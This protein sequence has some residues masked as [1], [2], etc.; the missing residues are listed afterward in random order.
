M[1]ESNIHSFVVSDY[2]AVFN[3]NGTNFTS[4]KVNENGMFNITVNDEDLLSSYIFSLKNSSSDNWYNYSAV[5]ISGRTSY[6]ANTSHIISSTNGQTLQWKYYVNDSNGT[7][8]ESNTYSFAVNNTAPG[9][10]L[11]LTP[12]PSNGSSFNTNKTLNWTAV[13][14]DNDVTYYYLYIGLS[15]PPDI[16]VINSLTY[17]NWTSNFTFDGIYY[18]RL[19][20]SD[21]TLNSSFTEIRTIIYD[22]TIPNVSL[23]SPLNNSDVSD[24]TPT[25]SFNATDNLASSLNYTIHVEG[26]G[27]DSIGEV[28]N[29]STANVDLNSQLSLGTHKIVVEITDQAG[30]K[31][32]STELFISVSAAIVYLNYPENEQYLNYRSVNFTFNVTDA[33]YSSLNCSLYIDNVYNR[34]NASTPINTKTQFFVTLAEGNYTWNVSCINA[35]GVSG[36][37][38][39][40]FQI[41]VTSPNIT[42]IVPSNDNTSIF[43]NTFSQNVSFNDSSLFQF[44]CVIYS[45]SALTNAV[46][47]LS[48]NVTGNLSY[49]KTDSVSIANLTDRKYYERCSVSDRE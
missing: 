12:T 32:N 27:I 16:A 4:I 40:R 25:I 36:Q 11:W 21:L 47:A 29:A 9:L 2:I 17:S 18:Y 7:M 10:P 26:T 6:F 49:V 24:P 3:Q 37:D 14:P 22:T 43:N 8:Y 35:A 5:D 23:I 44:E 48:R 19:L 38:S 30:N 45:D 46:W 41:D 13:D 15:N 28:N 31:I 42:W 1:Y 39:R 20:V 34:S 33:S